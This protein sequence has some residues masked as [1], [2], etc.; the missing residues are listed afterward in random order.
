VFGSLSQETRHP[1]LLDVLKMLHERGAA[2]LTTN[3]DDVLEKHCGIPRIG[4]SN[5]DDVSRFLRGELKGV[6]HIHGSYHD[7]HEVVLDTTDYYDVKSSSGV[8]DVLLTFLKCKTIL[9]IGCGAGLEDP[10][11]NALLSWASERYKNIPNRH[12][13]LIRDD[14]NIRY[15]PL[16]RV[17]YGPRYEDLI[18]YLKRLLECQTNI[19]S[20]AVSHRGVE[21][22]PVLIFDWQ[23]LRFVGFDDNSV[24]FQMS[25]CYPCE[26]CDSRITSLHAAIRE[27]NRSFI[28][29]SE[30][31]GGFLQKNA[32]IQL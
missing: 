26:V 31:D 10:N 3:Y 28:K 25:T 24:Y 11:F 27:N 12:C 6:F 19:Q 7:T 18:V 15:Q 4:R 5:Q 1:A 23:L 32:P 29:N 21:S 22:F 14:D 9:F 17:K 16:L 2:L 13:L 20:P 30:V 8:Q